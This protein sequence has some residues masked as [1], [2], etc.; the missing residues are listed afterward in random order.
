MTLDKLWLKAAGI[1]AIRTFAQAAIALLV[2]GEAV[3]K[4][5]WK[6]VLYVAVG[7]AILSLLTSLAGLPETK[8]DGVMTVNTSNPSKDVYSLELNK[9]VSTL[10]GMRTVTF[11]VKK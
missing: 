1:R 4:T 5:D 8:T 7:A 11:T 9:D 3:D 2:V 6:N 10:A